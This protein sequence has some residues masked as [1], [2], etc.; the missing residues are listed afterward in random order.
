MPLALRSLLVLLGTCAITLT[1][2]PAPAAETGT[3]PAPAASPAVGYPKVVLYS[4]SWCP[5]CKEAREYLRSKGIPFTDRDVEADDSAMNDLKNRYKSSGVPVMVIGED[6]KV[7][8]GFSPEK[9]ERAVEE[10]RQQRK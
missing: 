7:L 10:L 8:K 6:G 2:A 9:F 5:H 1:G 3:H 4:T